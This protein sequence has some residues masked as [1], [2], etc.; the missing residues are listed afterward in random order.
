MVQSVNLCIVT[1][2]R[3]LN[4][5]TL[6]TAM[7]IHVFCMTNHINLQINFIPDRSAFPKQLKSSSSD[8]IIL[9]DY[10]VSTDMDTIEKLVGEFPDGYRT[11]VVPCVTENVDWD[12]FKQKTLASSSEPASQRGL[13][14]DTIASSSS[15]KKQ[16]VDFVSSSSDGKLL[17]MDVKAVL[18][19]LRDAD[20][21]PY[22]S[23]D[24]IKKLGVKIGVLRSSNVTYNFPYECLGNILECSGVV[25]GP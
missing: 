22:K 1:K 13:T 17:A 6:H 2:N 11:L 20:N 9:V 8:R 14:F 21:V 24:Q 19:K 12:A 18:R 4:V 23:L 10:G 16:I 25:A 15:S 3:T 7:N 5:T